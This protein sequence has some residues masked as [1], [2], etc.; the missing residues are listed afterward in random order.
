MIVNRLRRLWRLLG[1]RR[2]RQV[3]LAAVLLVLSGFLE[4]LSLG[5]V[6]PM[7]LQLTR[8]GEGTRQSLVL[9]SLFCGVVLAAGGLRFL[10]LWCNTRLAGALGS[11]LA[12]QAWCAILLMPYPEQRELDHSQVVAMLAP[13]LRQLIQLVLLQALYAASAAALITGIASVLLALAWW[14]ALPALLVLACSY[15]LLSRFSRAP[16]VRHGRL[17][18][19]DQRLLIRQLNDALASTR[20]RILRGNALTAAAAFG[21]VDR[22]MRRHE[23]D[24]AA[25]TGLPRFVLEP[26]GIVT[27]V[28]V[29]LM[30]LTRGESP[31]RVLPLLGV[32]AFA[33]QRL[34]PLGQQLWSGWASVRSHAVLLDPLLPLLERPRPPAPHPPRLNPPPPLLD[35]QAAGLES[36]SFSYGKRQ[37]L[38]VSTVSFQLS[39]GEWLGL[40][41]ESGSGKTTVLDLL[42]GLLPAQN[43]A[44]VVDGQRLESDSELLRRWQAEIGYLGTGVSLTPGSLAQNICQERPLDIPWL[45]QLVEWLELEPLLQRQLGEGGSQLS[46]GQR[47]RVGLARALYGQPSLLILDEATSALDLEAEQRLLRRLRQVCGDLS[48][49]L[50]S[51][52]SASLAICDR[53]ID[54]TPHLD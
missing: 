36:V 13:Q 10:S 25:I 37:S 19:E 45:R 33:A 8:W 48:V 1:T 51:H 9:V 17:A 42:M 24:N 26:L 54:A 2:R 52:R 15:G 29:G 7:L 34:M 22:R 30:L 38:V 49:V 47:Q 11:D 12:E 4:M 35:W 18:A 43:G 28:M 31:E 44:L 14:A 46:G 39:R 50:V 53:L 27:I 3:S 6:L 21:V 20:E 40:R 32:M 41:G 23:A 5:L 16:L